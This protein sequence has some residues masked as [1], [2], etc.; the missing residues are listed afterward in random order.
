MIQPNRENVKKIVNHPLE[1][2]RQEFTALPREQ[3]IA[4]CYFPRASYF[5]WLN[6]PEE[7]PPVTAFQLANMSK[8]C[9]LT[10]YEVMERIGMDMTDIPKATKRKTLV[11]A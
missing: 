10:L 7:V 3:W 8:L 1:N 6:K 9:G 11:A 2:L 5:R 4:L